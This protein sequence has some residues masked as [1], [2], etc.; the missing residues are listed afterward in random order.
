MNNNILSF[1]GFAMLSS[2]STCTHGASDTTIF[3][4]LHKPENKLILLFSYAT[5]YYAK[6]ES[7]PLLEHII[8][9]LLHL[10]KYTKSVAFLISGLSSSLPHNNVVTYRKLGANIFRAIHATYCL[11]HQ[12]AWSPPVLQ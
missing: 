9:K 5:Y 7:I 10:N 6:E 12:G 1:T 11:Q 8:F 2:V 3:K 4:H